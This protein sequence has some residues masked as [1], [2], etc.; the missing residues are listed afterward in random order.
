LAAIVCL[1]QAGCPRSPIVASAR[2]WV[3][4][5][6]VVG[7]AAVTVRAAAAN[8]KARARAASEVTASSRLSS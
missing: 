8:A 1:V 3:L 6:A 2:V 5:S 4:V 7:A